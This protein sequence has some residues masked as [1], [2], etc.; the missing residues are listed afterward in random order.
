M[1]SVG[2]E[3][4]DGFCFVIGLTDGQLAEAIARTGKLRVIAL[5]D[6]PEKISS[7]RKQAYR[8]GIYG[9]RLSFSPVSDLGDLP[10]T[11]GIANLVVSELGSG[12]ANQKL[13][14]EIARMILYL[15]SDDSAF[16]TG[17]EIVTPARDRARLRGLH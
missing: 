8:K 4:Q 16:V 10:Y 1:E 17:A 9:E 11:D 14:D 6:D 7:L 15:I 12:L 13:A 3:I 2:G 5:S